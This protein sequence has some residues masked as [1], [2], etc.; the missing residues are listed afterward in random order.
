MVSKPGMGRDRLK[1][2]REVLDFKPKK[3]FFQMVILLKAN[4]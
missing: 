2:G 1:R 4:N 3:V